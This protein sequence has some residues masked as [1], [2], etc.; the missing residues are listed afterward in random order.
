MANNIELRSSIGTSPHTIHTTVAKVRI[1]KNNPI[2]PL[3]ISPFGAN[4]KTLWAI[5]MI[6]GNG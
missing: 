3:G 2:S 1:D 4:P 5:T 6:T